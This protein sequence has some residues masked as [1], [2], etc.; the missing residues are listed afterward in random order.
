MTLEVC[1]N[2][3]HWGRRRSEDRAAP[4]GLNYVTVAWDDEGRPERVDQL[5]TLD[6]AS[7]SGF[8]AHIEKRTKLRITWG[9]GRAN[10]AELCR[11]LYDNREAVGGLD[12]IAASKLVTI[13]ATSGKKGHEVELPI[14]DLGLFMTLFKEY[15]FSVTP[16]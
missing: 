3:A 15:G 14:R 2:C 7:C 9:R 1:A 11:K 16:A 13:A 12:L 8:E 5:V 10:L 4:C 6:R